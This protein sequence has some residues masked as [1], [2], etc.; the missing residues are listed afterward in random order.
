M[1]LLPELQGSIVQLSETNLFQDHLI[2]SNPFTCKPAS[3]PA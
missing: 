1:Q 2:D 3:E